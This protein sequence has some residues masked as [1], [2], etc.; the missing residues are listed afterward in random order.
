[1]F[2]PDISD[3]SINNLDVTHF[4]LSLSG[5]I[6]HASNHPPLFIFVYLFCWHL[7]RVIDFSIFT[8]SAK[9]T[10]N[11]YQLSHLIFRG[12]KMYTPHLL[13]RILSTN[14][15][16]PSYLIG[17]HKIYMQW[18]TSPCLM[19]KKK[20]FLLLNLKLNA[21]LPRGSSL[22]VTARHCTDTDL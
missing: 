10:L 7:V 14:Y 9:I 17:V 2:K 21:S 11:L 16:T 19:N 6:G 15:K 12:H 18:K 8:R 4:S 5:R 22:L 1:M 3:M 20:F 13:P